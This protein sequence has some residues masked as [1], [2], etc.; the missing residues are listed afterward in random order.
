MHIFWKR[1][2]WKQRNEK[3]I[4]GMERDGTGWGEL[5]ME[6]KKRMRDVTRRNGK[7]KISRGKKHE[8]GICKMGR[9]GKGKKCVEMN[10][11]VCHFPYFP[12]TSSI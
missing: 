11:R 10:F 4:G 12:L 8:E 5:V 7:W 9:D 3:G 1:E 2:P 6:T